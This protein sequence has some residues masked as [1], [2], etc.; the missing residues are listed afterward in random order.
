VQLFADI[1]NLL[2]TLRLWNTGDQ[3]YMTSLHLPRS[4][5]YPNIPGDDKVGDYREPGVAYQ[6]MENGVD[7]TQVGLPG[8]IYYQGAT[9]KYFEY[10]NSQWQEVDQGRLGKILGDKAYI[11]MPNASTYWFLDPRRVHFGLR[12]SFNFE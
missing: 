7:F 4:T 9:A 6:P 3:A 10:V 11:D 5:D 12:V 1:N 8:V 2:N